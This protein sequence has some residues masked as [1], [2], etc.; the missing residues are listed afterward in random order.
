MSIGGE[1]IESHTQSS[2]SSVGMEEITKVSAVHQSV[3]DELQLETSRRDIPILT[4]KDVD[5]QALLGS[6]SFSEV[7]SVSVLLKSWMEYG[8]EDTTEASS[9]TESV[10]Q[11]SRSYYRHTSSFMASGPKY[12]I[13]TIRT[14][15]QHDRV[16]KALAVRDAYYEA[17]ILSHLPPHPNIVGFVAVGEGFWEDPTQGFIILERVSE[18]LKHRLARWARTTRSVKKGLSYFQFGKKHRA[19]LHEQRNRIESAG[20]GIARAFFFIHKHKIVYRDLKP[21]NV[22]FCYDGTVKLF[23]FGLARRHVPVKNQ[24]R[25]LTGNAGTARYM[26]PEVSNCEDYSLPAD[27]HSYAIL[28]WEICTLEKPYANLSSLDQLKA[29]AV[30]SHRRP[31]LRNKIASPHVRELL[32]ACWDPDPRTRPTFALVLKEVEAAAGLEESF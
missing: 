21:A 10:E 23:D 14:D 4:H 26:A 5:C 15:L 30:N 16:L 28:L 8:N 20:V 2:S 31:A 11:P 18:T 7:F 25:R 27:I 19:M 29:N 17:E 22:G 13:K 6:G 9:S 24:P 12:A 3:L 32:K 1:E